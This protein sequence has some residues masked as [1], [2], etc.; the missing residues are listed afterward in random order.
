M[1]TPIPAYRRY[2]LGELCAELMVTPSW[3]RKLE[4]AGILPSPR[5]KKR[6]K[7]RTYTAADRANIIRAMVYRAVDLPLE[8]IAQMA[9]LSRG[10]GK[11]LSR[12]VT[13]HDLRAIFRSL[14]ES[15]Q[16]IVVA[17]TSAAACVEK[18]LDLKKLSGND[19]KALRE[20]IGEYLSY[21]DRL[22]RKLD[23]LLM[24]GGEYGREVCGDMERYRRMLELLGERTS[25]AADGRR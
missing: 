23:V 12:C 7:R 19:R 1:A 15:I 16:N 8:D 18:R 4:S 25:A 17:G 5:D 14:G 21:L 3:V 24:W 6:G 9:R 2:Q 10:I 11:V 22:K 20:L 13:D